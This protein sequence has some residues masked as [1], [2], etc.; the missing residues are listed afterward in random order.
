V[1]LDG[2]VDLEWDVGKSLWAD[3]V[4]EFQFRSGVTAD[5][6]PAILEPEPS[7]VWDL[8]SI[9]DGDY[10]GGFAAGALAVAGLV[11]GDSAGL[12]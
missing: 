11:P 12:H 3:F 7:V 4:E 6:W 1:D 2:W 9:I 5:D 8:S 10:P